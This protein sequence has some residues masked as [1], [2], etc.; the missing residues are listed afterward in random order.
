MLTLLLTGDAKWNSRTY[1]MLFVLVWFSEGIPT[2]QQMFFRARV[3]LFC[4]FFPFF[5]PRPSRGWPNVNWLREMFGK[6]RKER[7]GRGEPRAG[8][9][10]ETG[11]R[12]VRHDYGRLQSW[13]ATPQ[14][15]VPRGH[16]QVH[17]AQVH[18]LRYTAL[19]G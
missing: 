7:A 17:S 15:R 12:P 13:K 3:F 5:F 8:E 18:T 10:G 6:W 16:G 9:T 1:K 11:E 19:C 14:E 4:F 2:L